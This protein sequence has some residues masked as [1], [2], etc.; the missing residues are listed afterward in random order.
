MYD[1]PLRSVEEHWC[2]WLHEAV[3]IGTH[4]P[5]Y[6]WL[7]WSSISRIRPAKNGNNVNFWFSES[8]LKLQ[9]ISYGNL[10]H[11]YGY[12]MQLSP[13]SVHS[14][15]FLRVPFNFESDFFQKYKFLNQSFQKCHPE[16]TFGIF[17]HVCYMPHHFRSERDHTLGGI[18]PCHSLGTLVPVPPYKYLITSDMRAS[19]QRSSP[20][21]N[22]DGKKSAGPMVSTPGTWAGWQWQGMGRLFA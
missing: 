10:R 13:I 1:F 6:R 22:M 17:W 15:L 4:S 19:F 3:W 5:Y 9:Y 14:V 20:S 8:A 11:L 18:T 2:S 12:L 21:T 7:S 16:S